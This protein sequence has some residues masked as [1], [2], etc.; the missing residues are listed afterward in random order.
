VHMIGIPYMGMPLLCIA[1]LDEISAACAEEG[2]WH[3]F[4]SIAPWRFKGAT[5]SPVNPLA[6]F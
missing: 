5:S 3:F 2:R 6:I 4:V 1:G